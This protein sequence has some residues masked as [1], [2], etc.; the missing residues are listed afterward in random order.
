MLISAFCALGFLSYNYLWFS[1]LPHPSPVHGLP[2][3]SILC[4][5]KPVTLSI[6]ALDHLWSYSLGSLSLDHLLFLS[7]S[8]HGQ[9]QSAGH[10]PS[11]NLSPCS[12]LFQMPLAALSLIIYNKHLPL[13]HTLEQLWPHFTLLIPK[14]LG[15][16][17]SS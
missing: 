17:D 3:P 14:Q 11:T 4:P 2:S 5:Y 9:I 1:H 13:N 15:S 8:S 6:C 12:G 10:I 7:G 16:M